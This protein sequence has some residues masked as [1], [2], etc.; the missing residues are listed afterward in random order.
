MWVKCGCVLWLLLYLVVTDVT[1]INIST[2]LWLWWGEIKQKL[3]CHIWS[4]CVCTSGQKSWL[5]MWFGSNMERLYLKF[6][7]LQPL[8]HRWSTFLSLFFLHIYTCQLL[9]FIK[10]AYSF[11]YFFSLP[12]SV[13]NYVTSYATYSLRSQS[14]LGLLS[15]G[16][17]RML[18]H[19]RVWRAAQRF[20]RTASYHSSRRRG[21][22]SGTFVTWSRLALLLQV[23]NTRTSSTKYQ[24]FISSSFSQLKMQTRIL[25]LW[26]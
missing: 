22:L 5:W 16:Q 11:D 2:Y 12:L 7:R 24:R 14:I 9:S 20:W 13:I 19:Q 1:L 23:T 18:R 17:S 25:Y 8:Q 26:S 4:L 21:R 10:G 15:A 6:L 3:M